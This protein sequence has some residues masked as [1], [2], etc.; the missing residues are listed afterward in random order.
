[1]RIWT[2][3]IESFIF[4]RRTPLNSQNSIRKKF[5]QVWEIPE[6]SHISGNFC[7]FPEIFAQKRIFRNPRHI[8]ASES[9]KNK[10][11]GKFFRIDLFFKVGKHHFRCLRALSN[12][13]LAALSPQKWSQSANFKRAPI[14]QSCTFPEA[15]VLLQ[16]GTT[17][18]AFEHNRGSTSGSLGEQ[19]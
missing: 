11:R 14:R 19:I 13:S 8:G 9:E 6:I 2:V 18:G 5:E 15:Q 10:F 16:R 12:C 4:C 17:V 1:M 3:R 7:L